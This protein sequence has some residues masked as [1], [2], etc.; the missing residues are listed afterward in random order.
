[1]GFGFGNE[2][3]AVIMNHPRVRLS[4]CCGGSNGKLEKKSGDME[5]GIDSVITY[6]E[7]GN[8]KEEVMQS[9]D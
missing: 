5:S 9:K 3:N 7:V 2:L 6:E 8:G 1:L 4:L